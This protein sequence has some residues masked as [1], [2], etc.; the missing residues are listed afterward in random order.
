MAT[1]SVLLSKTTVGT[2][3]LPTSKS[4]YLPS[5][6]VPIMEDLIRV[7]EN[8]T[9]S[10][11][12]KIPVIAIAGC[13]GVGKTHV[14]HLFF[15]ELTRHS[16]SCAIV[17]FDDWTNPPGKER[18]DYFNL[19][20]VHDFFSSLVSGARVID[21][22]VFNE[23]TGGHSHE[24]LDLRKVDII[25]FEGLLTLSAKE[26]FNYFPYCDLGIFLEAELQD[27]S[28]WKRSRPATAP[29]SDKE[30]A[31][32]ME[33]VF[34]RY[35]ENIKPFEKNATWILQKDSNHNYSPKRN[36]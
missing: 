34:A 35:Q 2:S 23:F 20:G 29:L 8:K 18:G 12:G 32:H 24:I 14:A 22:P 7:K 10:L 31:Q 15:Q 28:N 11:S 25:I 13:P 21:K 3:G 17:H 26:P 9:R 1:Q 36:K 19:Q 4:S 27:I 16:I 33:A 6:L 30:F 5:A